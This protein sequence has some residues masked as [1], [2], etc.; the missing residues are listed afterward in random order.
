MRLRASL[1]GTLKY[2]G[3]KK[4]ILAAAILSGIVRTT[5]GATE[6]ISN[7]GFENGTQV[8][9]FFV[10]AGSSIANQVNFSH[11]GAFYLT[12][13]N[14]N[15]AFQT[16][17]QIV[18]VPSN[19]V[20]KVVLR[21]F[22]AVVSQ[23]TTPLSDRFRVLITDTNQNILAVVDT[24][25]N[26]SG[27]QGFYFQKAFDMS[28]FIGQTVVLKFEAITESVNGFRTHFYIDDVSIQA[29]SAADIP[30]NDD[31][32]NRIPVTLITSTNVVATNTFASKEIGEPNHGNDSGGR[33]LW[34][35][36]TAPAGGQLSIDTV[37]STFTTT[38][39]VYTGSSVSNLTRIAQSNG[40]NEG[41]GLA[42]VKFNV[43]P[44]T[45][46]QI[47][48]DGNDGDIGNVQ[49]RF[50]FVQDLKLPTITFTSP[51]SGIKVTNATVTISG[52]A[53]DNIGVARVEYQVTPI[54][55][56]PDYIAADG[57]N[58][59]S[60]TITNLTL[61]ANDIRVRSV[62]VTGNQS[63]TL[64]RSVISIIVSTF[65]LNIVGSGTVTPD[66]NAQPL[67]LGALYNVTAKPNAGWVFLGWSGPGIST[68]SP[69]LQFGMTSNLTITATFIPNPFIPLVGTYQGLFADTNGVAVES[70]GFISLALKNTGAFSAKIAIGG[71]SY[72]LSGQFDATG[73]FSGSLVRPNI[74]ALNV[75]L[76]LD[77][78]GS[79]ITGTV[80]DFVWTAQLRANRAVFSKT[81]PAPKAGKYTLAL[82]GADFSDVQPAGDCV[83]TITVD[84][85]G[86]LSLAGLLADNTKVSLKTFVSTNA[87]FPLFV[88]LYKGNGILFGWMTLTNNGS[89]DI[90]GVLTWIKHAQPVVFYP[91]GFTNQSSVRGS[92]YSFTAG[93]PI[94]SFT[95][96]Q[97]DISNGNLPSNTSFPVSIST[98]GKITST[99]GVAITI[100]TTS[101]AFKGTVPNPA[102]GKAIAVNGVI[103]QKQDFATGYF[104]GTNQ[105]GNVFIFAP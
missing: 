52:K 16:V 39:G 18:T 33:S 93:V 40:L 82:P 32:A 49:L 29:G 101:G 75:K 55:G 15:A 79:T 95:S 4:I 20:S 3:M 12:M 64:L 67:E 30:P 85:A 22:R 26:N 5:F 83:A 94:L 91:N 68:N 70:S 96:G 53:S 89:D 86:A 2:L 13:A 80:D 28:G 99:N 47:A 100:T 8:P 27:P 66:L 59:W 102:G 34:Y 23:N 61:G 37:G 97:L 19:N 21:Y 31:F 88:S 71:K 105:I 17:S 54:V 36:L 24:I 10:G 87:E 92:V 56:T 58:T 103:M 104:A 76:Q 60:A 25:Y 50:T 38:L 43:S 90:T 35:T 63:V 45:V 78:N 74:G 44:G 62:D 65:T 41:G 72:S 14:V 84:S 46:L 6:L 7:G 51:A 1:A 98:A 69:S 42:K 77:L 48:V 57:T 73:K 9:W 81:N 11:S